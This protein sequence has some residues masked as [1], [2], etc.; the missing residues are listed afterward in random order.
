MTA[1]LFRRAFPAAAVLSL[2][3]AATA[4]AGPEPTY[5]SLSDSDMKALFPTESEIKTALGDI[6]TVI[7]PTL[8]TPKPKITPPPN[9]GMS[10]DCYEASYGTAESQATEPT[11]M[12]VMRSSGS[13]GPSL[14]WALAQ[15]SSADEIKA[16]QDNL[17]ARIHRCDQFEEFD[18]GTSSGTS[19]IHKPF[20]H[21]AGEGANAVVT[22]GDVSLAFAVSN[23]SY[24]EAKE[25][26]KKMA[27]VMEKRLKASAPKS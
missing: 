18:A 16:G 8:Q 26:V 6:N 17:R 4:C 14:V 13:G 1:R 24:S 19:F 9:E 11:R 22:S 15:R 7:G 10:Q 12:F 23:V 5:S 2:L 25:L 27:P 3:L 21:G 20:E